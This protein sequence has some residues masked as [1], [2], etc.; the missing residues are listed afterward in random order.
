MN[1][2]TEPSR[3]TT[4]I[5]AAI[6]STIGVF[7]LTGV[8]SPELA[9]GLVTAIGAWVVVAGE[10]IRQRVTPNANVALTVTQANQLEAVY[11]V[12]AADE[13]EIYPEEDPTPRV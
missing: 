11:E 3:L 6:T 8:L 10:I 13:D 1:M 4:L 9:G 12:N 2:E 7:T 5:T